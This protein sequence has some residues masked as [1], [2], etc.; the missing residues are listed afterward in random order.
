M[1]K[2]DTEL[3][4][5]QDPD[6]A[7][8]FRDLPEPQ[9][10]QVGE[11]LLR[12]SEGMR[13]LSSHPEVA[14]AMLQAD[15]GLKNDP[16]FASL[17]SGT[18]GPRQQITRNGN[19]AGDANSGDGSSRD[20]SGSSI[21][22]SVDTFRTQAAAA[23]KKFDKDT[24]GII[25]HWD[26]ENDAM[27]DQGID[28]LTKQRESCKDLKAKAI[29]DAKIS[30]LTQHKAHQGLRAHDERTMRPASY[31]GDGPEVKL[32]RHNLDLAEASQIERLANIGVAPAHRI[33]IDL[34]VRESNV[35]TLDE[36]R[37]SRGGARTDYRS[38]GADIPQGTPPN[39]VAPDFSSAKPGIGQGMGGPAKISA[40][41]M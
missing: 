3:L 9:R 11:G 32:G 10:L 28:A 5:L 14:A 24:K 16:A 23:E 19:A 27:V 6:F 15:P 12:T 7:Q 34:P 35:V 33:H 17:T 25:G 13:F 37:K 39:K 20:S 41:G 21:E 18:N 2:P 31:S 22:I 36:Y 26:K 30:T 1:D 38:K 40:L 8:K 29:L 4:S